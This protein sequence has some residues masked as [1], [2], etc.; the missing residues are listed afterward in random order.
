MGNAA[1]VGWV[2]RS[3]TQH[4]QTRNIL[5]DAGL[6]VY[7]RNSIIKSFD[8]E[9]FRIEVV[10]EAKEIFRV[11]DA[12]APLQGRY[13]TPN[14]LENQI[15]RIIKYA[16]P[17]NAETRL[18]RVTLPEGATIF[19]GKVAPQIDLNLGLIVGEEQ[20]FLLGPLNQYKFEEIMI[21]RNTL[22]YNMR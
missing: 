6:S 7:E 21:P 22:N 20:S 1:S 5:K 3:A 15:D 10:S 12:A 2:K 11:F 14:L 18:G 16:L 9:T 4:N 8:L 13:T 17:N 19:S